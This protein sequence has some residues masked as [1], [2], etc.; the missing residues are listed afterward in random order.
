M[1]TKLVFLFNSFA[2]NALFDASQYEFFGQHA[3]EEVELG[4][5]ENDED[6]IQL[7]GS[8]DDEYQLFEREEVTIYPLWSCVQYA[9]EEVYWCP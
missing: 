1:L 3:M 7:F 4:G 5:L 8:V 2:D 9:V 6:D